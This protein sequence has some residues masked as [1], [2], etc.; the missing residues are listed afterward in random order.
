MIK[1]I[2]TDDL[3]LFEKLQKNDPFAIKIKALYKAYGTNTDFLYFYKITDS[4]SVKAILCRM[5]GVVTISAFDEYDDDELYYFCK[6]FGCILEGCDLD[7][8]NRIPCESGNIITFRN[9]DCNSEPCVM[10]I[11]S[12][13]G[14]MI[15]ADSDSVTLPMYD[16]FY[17]DMSHRIRHGISLLYGTYEENQPIGAVLVSHI[18]DDSSLISGVALKKEYRGRNLGRELLKSVVASENREGRTVYLMCI[19]E[20]TDF[21]LKCGGKIC[22]KFKRLDFENYEFSD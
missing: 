21:Y 8:Q 3:Q 7:I 22:G 19:D 17:V 12:A 16:D 11:K 20:L 13:Y 5:N 6:F 14:V 18:V 1:L 2:S 4:S 10:D 9:V 15:S